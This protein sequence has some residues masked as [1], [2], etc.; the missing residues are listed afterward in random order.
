MALKSKSQARDR[1]HS[2]RFTDVDQDKLR[3][4]YYTS[5]EVANWLSEWAIR[6]PNDDILEPSCGDGIFLE[7]AVNRFA[8]LGVRGKSAASRLK[9]V[10]I[11]AEEARDA[12][13]RL[14]RLVGEHARD[15]VEIA[16]FFGWWQART[17]PSFDVVV[18]NP[19]FIRYQIFPEPHRSRAMAIMAE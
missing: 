18:G 19:P 17:Q 16:D 4:G 5:K 11:V 10:E 12:R 13:G 6:S 9:G 1:S 8:Q 14:E 7:A 2:G 15:V 3:G